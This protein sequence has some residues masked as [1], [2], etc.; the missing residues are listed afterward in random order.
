MWAWKE[1]KLERKNEVPKALTIVHAYLPPGSLRPETVVEFPNK[2]YT[3]NPSST[4]CGDNINKASMVIFY[5][6]WEKCNKIQLTKNKLDLHKSKIKNIKANQELE[7]NFP[8]VATPEISEWIIC[9]I[10]IL[11]LHL[12]AAPWGELKYNNVIYYTFARLEKPP[13][14]MRTEP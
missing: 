9:I 14:H 4:P 12:L 8:G 2:I 11:I 3:Y 7:P 13:S 5:K 1:V 6:A 10:S